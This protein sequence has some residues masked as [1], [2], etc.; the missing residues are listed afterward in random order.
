M[1]NHPGSHALFQDVQKPPQDERGKTQDVME[2]AILMANNLNQALLDLHALGSAR[3]DPYLCDFL[4][5]HF[6][7]EE[8]KLI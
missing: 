7:D 1:Q 2:A 8:V 6:L 3:A 4:K 5:S